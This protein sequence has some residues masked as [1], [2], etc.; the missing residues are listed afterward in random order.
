MLRTFSI[1]SPGYIK[2]RQEMDGSHG[3]TSYMGHIVQGKKSP[4]KY[5]GITYRDTSLR[6]L[7]SFYLF[8]PI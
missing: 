1:V 5:G 4:R 3:D 8:F 6:L 2:I 7:I